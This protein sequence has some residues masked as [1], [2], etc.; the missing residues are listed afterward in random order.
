MPSNHFILCCPLFL[1]SP[2]CPSIRVFSNESTLHMR[3]PKFSFSIG[4]SREHPG[5]ISRL[6]GSPCSPRDSQESSPTLQFKSINSLLLSLH[7][8]P[9]LTYIHD[10]WKNHSFDY[11]DLCWKSNI[12]AFL[13]AVEFCHSYYKCV[14]Y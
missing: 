3:W 13:Y 8:G 2:I 5:L 14:N 11:T 6:D 12:S 7:Y 1:L 4:P 9:T 10:Y